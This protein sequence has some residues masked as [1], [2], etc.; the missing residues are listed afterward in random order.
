MDSFAEP[1]HAK[2]AGT[3]RRDTAVTFTGSKVGAGYTYD[4]LPQ[5]AFIAQHYKDMCKGVML[6]GQQRRCR[7]TVVRAERAENA[8]KGRQAALMGLAL[9]GT[10]RLC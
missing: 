3:R 2:S 5:A 9:H 8:G 4:P 1:K 6:V 10:I 7:A